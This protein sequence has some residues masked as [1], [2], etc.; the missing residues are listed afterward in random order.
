MASVP[1]ATKTAEV[2]AAGLGREN[3]GA[4]RNCHIAIPHGWKRPKLIVYSNLPDPT[5]GYRANLG[6]PATGDIAPYNIGPAVYEGG[7][8]ND[9]AGLG[10]GQMNGLAAGPVHFLEATHVSFDGGLTSVVATAGSVANGG[11]LEIEAF[12]Y[13]SLYTNE[14][15]ANGTTFVNWSSSQCNACGHHTTTSFKN[16]TAVQ[17]PMSFST[18]ELNWSSTKPANGAWK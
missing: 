4:C 7:A 11:E 9:S 5:P 1:G 3:A 10:S 12:D 2:I 6:L 18:R 8:L 14:N 17:P 15:P 16:P 13:P